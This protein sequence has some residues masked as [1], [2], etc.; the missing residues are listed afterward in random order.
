MKALVKIISNS[1]C[2]DDC[3]IENCLVVGKSM[4]VLFPTDGV[5]SG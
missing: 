1:G 5:P 2:T 4:H 3:G